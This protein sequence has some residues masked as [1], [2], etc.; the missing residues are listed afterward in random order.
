MFLCFTLFNNYVLCRMDAKCPGKIPTDDS[1]DD[2]DDVSSGTSAS[3]LPEEKTGASDRKVF[4]ANPTAAL[5][6]TPKR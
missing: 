6:P 5:E 2:R 1:A 3:S 4:G